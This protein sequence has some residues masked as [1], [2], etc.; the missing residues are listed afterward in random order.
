MSDRPV[1]I[2]DMDHLRRVRDLAVFELEAVD[3]GNATPEEVRETMRLIF[4]I[5]RKYRR[6]D[7]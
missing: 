5:A 2:R 7:A 3:K 6:T 1:K 4:N